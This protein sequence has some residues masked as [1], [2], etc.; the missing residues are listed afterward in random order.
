MHFCVASLKDLFKHVNPGA[1]VVNFIK[2]IHYF[3]R[4]LFGFTIFLLNYTNILVIKFF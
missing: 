4:T 2:D 1:A 3:D